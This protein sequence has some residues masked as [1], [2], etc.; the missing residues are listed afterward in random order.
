MPTPLHRRNLILP[1][2]T[3]G[4]QGCMFGP[5]L[6][7]AGTFHHTFLRAVVRE[8]KF[9]RHCC[10]TDDLPRRANLTTASFGASQTRTSDCTSS[11]AES[12]QCSAGRHPASSRTTGRQ[13]S[14]P[15]AWLEIIEQHRS[16]SSPHPSR[17]SGYG[18]GET[19]LTWAPGMY[20]QGVDKSGRLNSRRRPV[21]VR[22]IM[23]PDIPPRPVRTSLSN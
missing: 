14:A 4:R 1:C 23:G 8:Y 16:P 10:S 20:L 9:S 11:S 13:A 18:S 5:I 2:R 12:H 3:L 17:S 15:G 22:T 7:G 19:L 6:V 21:R